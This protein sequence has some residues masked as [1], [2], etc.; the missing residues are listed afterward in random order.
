MKKFFKKNNPLLTII[1]VILCLILV[2][3]I[4]QLL[5]KKCPTRESFY[6]S[7]VKP[8]TISYNFYII[9]GTNKD[10]YIGYDENMM[11]ITTTVLPTDNSYI[12]KIENYR[13]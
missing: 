13:R 3:S 2:V 6:A 4:I 8:V 12:F 10:T 1:L 7:N 9:T 5:N 11:M